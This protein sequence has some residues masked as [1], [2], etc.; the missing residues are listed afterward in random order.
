MVPC[1][2]ILSLCFYIS[3]FLCFFVPP[4][5]RPSGWLS[6]FQA[7][8]SGHLAGLQTLWM[9]SQALRLASKPSGWPSWPFGW[10]PHPVDDVVPGPQA[11][12]QTL[13]LAF[14]ALWGYWLVT[15]NNIILKYL[16]G[17]GYR[18][19]NNAWA[20][21]SISSFSPSSS[22]SSSSCF[23]RHFYFSLICISSAFSILE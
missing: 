9:T 14:Q 11:G 21:V 3:T 6:D 2:E 13:R 4:L 7:G 1:R 23:S 22:Y 10:P 12:F 5:S 17:T 16:R 15:S 8:L 20:T 18:W 19:P